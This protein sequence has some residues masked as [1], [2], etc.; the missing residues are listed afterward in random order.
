VAARGNLTLAGTRITPSAD[1]LGASTVS[2]VTAARHD[3][4]IAGGFLTW[5]AGIVALLLAGFTFVRL[6]RD[7]DAALWALVQILLVALARIDIATRRLPNSI[8]APMALAAIVLRLLFERSSLLEV[9]LAGGAAFGVFL[10]VAILA[11]GGFGMGDVKLAGTLGLL[12]GT[13]VVGALVVGILAGGVYSACLLATRRA[14]LR[15][16]LAYGPFL[17]FG[18]VLAI[19]FTNPPPLV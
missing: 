18:G 10:G 13:Q 15:S 4:L 11:R 9:V 7:V 8:Q 3:R 17:A 12:L 2:T 6:G 16:T 5:V 19:L 1:I 14:R